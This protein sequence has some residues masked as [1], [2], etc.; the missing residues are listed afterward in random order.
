MTYPHPNR[1][2]VPQAVLTRSGKI[3][4]AGASVNT[5]VRPVNTAGSKTTVNHPRPISNAYKKGYS[6]VTRPF[7]KDTT[8]RDRAVVSENKEKGVNDVKASACWIQVYNGLDPQKSLILLFYMPGNPHQ[9]E[10]KEKEVF[11]SGCFRYMIGNKFYLTEYEDYDGGFVS[12]G[13]GKGRISGK[14]VAGNQTNGIAGTRDNIVA[15]Q[16]KKKTELE[17]EYILIPFGTTN[18]LISQG[19]KDSEEDVDD[20]EIFGN[21]YDDE[22]VSAEADLNN[23]EIAINVSL[24]PT[25]RINKDHPKDQIIGDLNLAIQTRRMTKVS[26]E[27]TMVW[28]LVDLPNGKRA[29]GTKWVFRNKKDKRGIVVRNKARLVVQGFIVYHMD[30][31]SAFLYGTIEEEMSSMGELTLFL[32]LQVQQKD[33]ATIKTA[34]TPIETNKALVKDEEAEAIDVYL[35]RSMIGSLMYLTASRPDIMFVVCACAR[36]SPFDLETFSDSDYARASLDRKSTIGGCQFLGRILILWQCKKQTIVANYTT[37]AEYVAAA[38]CYGQLLWIQNQMLYYGFKFMNTKIYIDNESTICID[39][40]EKF[41]PVCQTGSTT[42]DSNQSLAISRHWLVHQLDVKNA[43]LHGSFIRGLYKC[44]TSWFSGSR[45]QIGLPSIGISFMGLKQYPSGPVFQRFAAYAARVGFHHS[46][47]DSSL[48]IYRQG[49]DTAYLLLYVDDIV[50]TASSSDLLQQIITS[51]HERMFQISTKY[52]TEVL[53][54]A[55]MLNCKRVVTP[56][57]TDSKLFADF[58]AVQQSSLVANSDADLGRGWSYRGVA[59]AVVETCWLCNILCELHTPLATATLFYCDNVS[60]VYLSSNPV[61]HQ[62]T[63]HIEIDI[64]FVRDLVATGAIRVLHVPSRYHLYGPWPSDERECNIKQQWVKGQD[65]LWIPNTHPHLL[66]TLIKNHSLFYHH[67]KTHKPRQAKRITKISQSS[68]PIHLVTNETVHKELGD[69]MERAA[70][71]AFSLE[72]EHD[73]GN[74]NRTQSI[75]TLN[76]PSP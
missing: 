4:T 28:T 22:D 39:L 70:T 59:N 40:D 1:R 56:V 15:G 9:K 62:R 71:T 42:S 30:V 19:P 6:Q 13:D 7:N 5:A 58:Y 24:I 43:F 10:Y 46:R 32:G 45:I 55:C 47:C 54:R 60:A 21:A 69:R 20:T 63:K 52:A 35:Y 8:A 67:L 36:D 31:K 41:G 66:N 11:D 61:Q 68:R 64:H 74:I 34:S 2:F 72:A 26:D 25:T 37:E 44:T 73:S 3:N 38:N 16:A 14:V 18:P 76:E 53:D 75:A 50:L 17:Q 33:F 27:H 48:F 65:N 57:V 23:L 12:F 51:L 29:I 49:A